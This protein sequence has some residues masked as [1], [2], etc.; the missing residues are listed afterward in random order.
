MVQLTPVFKGPEKKG[1]TGIT[2]M[3][4]EG[5]LWVSPSGRHQWVGEVVCGSLEQTGRRRN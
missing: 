2:G 5:R 3:I 4:L 1:E